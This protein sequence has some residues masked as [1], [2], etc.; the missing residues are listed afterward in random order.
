MY[1]TRCDAG[2]TWDEVSSCTGSSSALSWNNGTTNWTTTGIT[3][4]TTGKSNS[5]ALAA[6]ADAGA[7]Y[8]AANYCE[9]LNTNGHADWYLPA[10]SELNVLYTNKAVIR[11]FN[12]SGSYWSSTE[13]NNKYNANYER[14]S[15]GN[16][17]NGTKSSG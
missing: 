11:N 12:V 17:A 16:Q 5:A 15:D 7:T 14:F 6:L 1:T 13:T 2:Q 4:N 3:G 9:T 8:V 10:L